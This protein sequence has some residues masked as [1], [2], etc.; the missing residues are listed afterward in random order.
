MAISKPL[1]AED[2]AVV[3]RHYRNRTHAQIATMIGRSKHCV[4]NLCS[5]KGWVTRDDHWTD[6]EIAKLIAWYRRPGADGRDTLHLQTLAAELGREKVNVCRKAKVLGLTKQSRKIRTADAKKKISERT[7][8]YIRENG[9]PRG[10][11]GLKHSPE[12]RKVLSEKSRNGWERRKKQPIL[13][14]LKR[15]QTVRTNLER[16]GVASPV[17][18]INQGRNVYSR[19]KRG[20]REDLGFFVRS[21]WE[22]NYARYLMWMKGRGEISSWEYE[23]T[24]FRFDG[25]SRGPYTYK[26]DFLVVE[27][28]GRRAYHEVKGWM[29]SASRG[30]LKRFA[31]FY[32][33]HAMVVVDAKAYR[34]IQ[35]KLSTVIPNW[36]SE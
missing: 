35:R 14:H 1:T 22:A 29:D 10:A 11:L 33:E 13:M 26:P 2:L 6:Q 30:R 5:R 8:K 7:K 25:V 34:E 3:E 15:V 18:A 23:P 36:E 19:C 16:Y 21:R 31:K 9:H 27:N 17:Q 20:V 32:P 24:T 12:T 28:D 4:R